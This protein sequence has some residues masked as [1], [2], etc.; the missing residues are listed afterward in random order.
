MG[1][2]V[3]TIFL[4]I[5]IFLFLFSVLLFFYCIGGFDDLIKRKRNINKSIKIRRMEERDEL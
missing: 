3:F 5:F 2:E 4:F 1:D